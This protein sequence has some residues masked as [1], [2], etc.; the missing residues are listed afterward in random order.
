[1]ADHLL[2]QSC[3]V[4][5]GSGT[6]VVPGDRSAT[7][8]LMLECV[9]AFSDVLQLFSDVACICAN[10]QVSDVLQLFSDVACP[11]FIFFFYF[12]FFSFFS[13]L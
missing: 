6:P 13:L 11:I 8:G 3:R 2:K 1:M 4:D 9:K 12:I 7:V 5:G 10:V